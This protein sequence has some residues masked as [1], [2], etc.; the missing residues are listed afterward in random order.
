MYKGKT[1]QQAS[2]FDKLKFVVYGKIAY[3]YT[4]STPLKDASHVD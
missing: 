4:V 3:E 1:S 2:H